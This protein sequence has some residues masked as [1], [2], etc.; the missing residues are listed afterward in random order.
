VLSSDEYAASASVPSETDVP[1]DDGCDNESVD[2]GDLGIGP[3]RDPRSGLTEV[4]A[5]GKVDVIRGGTPEAD[6]LGLTVK[7]VRQRVPA[8]VEINTG[9]KL[10]DH[11]R[12]LEPGVVWYYAW[13]RRSA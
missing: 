5:T 8:D 11:P 13:G 12:T 1:T 10:L 7:A 2:A 6:V 9:L 4:E 3:S